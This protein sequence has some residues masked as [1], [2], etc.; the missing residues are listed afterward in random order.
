[1]ELQK[2]AE[3]ILS[4]NYR[5]GGYTVPS[6]NLYPFQW[7][8]DSGFIAIGYAYFDMDKAKSEI[9]SLL[10]GQWE[11]GLIPHIIFHQ[12]SDSY[13][14]GPDFHQ[15]ILHPKSVKNKRSTGM[16]QPPV[17]GFVLEKLYQIA[18]DKDDI[19]E[20]IKAVIDKVYANHVYFYS[21]RDLQDE[22]LVY[23]YHNWESGTDNSPIWDDIWETMDSPSYTFERRDTSHVDPSQRPN[24]REYDHYLHIIEIAKKYNYDDQGIAENSPFLVQDPLFNA[25]LSQSNQSL[26]RLYGLIGEAEDK[27]QYLKEKNAKTIHG[28]NTKLFNQNLGV[29]THYDMRKEQQIAK[30]TSSSFAP[31]YCGA[32]TP[33]MAT[34]MLEVLEENFGGQD[35]YL[36]ASFDPNDINFNPKKYWRGPVWINLNWIL[37]Q[38]FKRYNNH[39]L[40][41]R[42]KQDSLELIDKADFYEYFDPIKAN[43]QQGKCGYGG[44]NFSWSAALTLSFIHE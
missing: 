7:K 21:Q 35:K 15:S 9:E 20:F 24:K 25:I 17:L 11:N 13:F 44:T 36:C 41:E 42:I 3:K 18:S 43:H 29:Y 1:M 31:L 2:K 5:E 22:G 40:A 10:S 32:P 28:L 27:I 38:G 34:R 8:W 19:L 37:F 30:I 33:T 14:P 16:T 23:I 6:E 39:K 12:E 4:Q 26:I